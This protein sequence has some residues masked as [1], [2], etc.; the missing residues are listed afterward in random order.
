[1]GIISQLFILDSGCVD[2]FNILYTVFLEF[3]VLTA[4]EDNLCM[5]HCLKISMFLF[6]SIVIQ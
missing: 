5:T 1:V 3:P 4:S 6:Y 2:V